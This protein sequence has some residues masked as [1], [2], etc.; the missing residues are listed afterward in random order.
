MSQPPQCLTFTTIILSVSPLVL[1]IQSVHPSLFLENSHL[2][3]VK[4]V[5]HL[6]HQL[7]DETHQKTSHQ[8]PE[9]HS[10]L[11]MPMH[12]AWGRY[13]GTIFSH[14][15]TQ[16]YMFV[17][18]SRTP[19]FKHKCMKVIIP[20]GLETAGYSFIHLG[21]KGSCFDDYNDEDDKCQHH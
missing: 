7:H 1:N 9:L 12:P 4:D 3:S 16:S 8:R 17:R 6:H 2:M 18:Q 15:E 21:S 20:V 14:Q 19:W 13:R 10:T 11:Q 5:R